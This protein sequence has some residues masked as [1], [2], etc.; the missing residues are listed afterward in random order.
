MT[1]AESG[2]VYMEL[3]GHVTGRPDELNEITIEL[4][5]ISPDGKQVSVIRQINVI[6]ILNSATK[7]L[8][9]KRS[10]SK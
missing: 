7:I 2:H 8:T 3:K 4:I 5:D 9:D 10:K 1:I 6:S